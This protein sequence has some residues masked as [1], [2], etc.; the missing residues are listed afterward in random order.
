MNVLL[1]LLL[2]SFTQATFEQILATLV[3]AILIGLTT[4]V[5]V[6]VLKLQRCV[7]TVKSMVEGHRTRID[8]HSEK[9]NQI[10]KSIDEISKDMAFVNGFMARF[11]DTSLEG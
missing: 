11:E 1:A 6:S 10:D 4:W 7:A 2:A 5:L 8:K 3:S 9:F